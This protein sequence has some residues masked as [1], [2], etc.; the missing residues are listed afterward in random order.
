MAALAV[1]IDGNAFRALALLLALRQEQ[2]DHDSPSSAGSA[3]KVN[4]SE[5]KQSG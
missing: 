1:N 5:E 4:R 3:Q 2:P